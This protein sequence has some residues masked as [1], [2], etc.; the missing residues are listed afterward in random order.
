MSDAK[1]VRLAGSVL[2]RSRH[3]CAFFRSKDE[4]YRVLLP[5]IKEG[6]EQGDRA[7]H[8]ID[9]DRRQDHMRR[10]Q[11]ARIDTAG[12]EAEERLVVHHWEDTYLQAGQIDVHRQ[13]SLFERVLLEGKKQGYPLT[14]FVAGTE[15][16]LL[17][18][19]GVHDLIEYE[20][21][22]NDMFGKYDDPV[23]C[24]YDVSKFSVSVIMGRYARAC[25]RDHKRD[26]PGKPVFRPARGIPARAARTGRAKRRAGRLR[27]PRMMVA[28]SDETLT[29]R[30]TM[31]DLV[32]LSALPAVWTGYRP[33]QVAE[34]LTDVLLSTLRL[35]LTGR[36]A[37]HP[38][39]LRGPPR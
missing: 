4:E 18:R 2:G 5:F 30:R 10:L 28:G 19:P 25:G 26:P 24:T 16:A 37:P 29:L 21:R 14:H 39:D 1:P 15:W 3:V 35:D 34:S 17:D 31:R 8:I 33:L 20:S 23:C 22:F 13:I 6:F 36:H 9:A 11:E 12:A 32:A 38:V 7:F 27:G